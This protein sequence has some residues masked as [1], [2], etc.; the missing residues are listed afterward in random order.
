MV[1]GG[2][3]SLEGCPAQEGEQGPDTLTEWELPGL[4]GEK[5][6]EK[7]LLPKSTHVGTPSHSPSHT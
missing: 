5:M 6:A 3:L 2:A 7:W 4:E 1:A